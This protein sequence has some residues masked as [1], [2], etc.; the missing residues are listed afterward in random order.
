MLTLTSI[1]ILVVIRFDRRGLFSFPSGGF[2][3]NVIIFGVDMSF[4]AR[5]DNKKKTF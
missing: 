5:I 4:S 2:R 3:G 1:G